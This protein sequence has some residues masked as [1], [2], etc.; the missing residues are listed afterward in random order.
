MERNG[1]IMAVRWRHDYLRRNGVKEKSRDG[2]NH[3]N[4]GLKGTRRL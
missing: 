2:G 1:G 3:H 4:S